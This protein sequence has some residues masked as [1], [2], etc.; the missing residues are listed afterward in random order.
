MFINKIKVPSNVPFTFSAEYIN[1]LSDL[2]ATVNTELIRLNET[3][4]S[5]ENSKLST[6]KTNLKSAFDQYHKQIK[7]AYIDNNLKNNASTMNDSF[8]D[9]LQILNHKINSKKFASTVKNLSK[10]ASMKTKIKKIEECTL[11]PF[12]S[13]DTFNQQSVI[14]LISTMID[15]KFSKLN[16]NTNT[17]KN[18]INKKKNSNSKKFTN[19]KSPFLSKSTLPTKPPFH[20]EVNQ[21]KETRTRGREIGYTKKKRLYSHSGSD[22]NTKRKKN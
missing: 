12:N 7:Q 1:S 18:S 4:I 13:S 11:P 14:D 16:L 10:E 5:L 15:T 3:K 9:L 20:K 21:P 22:F 19:N 6:S 8:K 17:N 2:N